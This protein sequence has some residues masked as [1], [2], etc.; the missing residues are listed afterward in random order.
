M[1]KRFKYVIAAIIFT[2]FSQLATSKQQQEVP[3]QALARMQKV[4]QELATPNKNHEFLAQLAGDWTT[5]SKVLG[6]PAE[7]GKAQY[8]M[9]LG[10]RFLHGMRSGSVAGVPFAGL[11]TLGYDNYK[12]KFVASYVDN[13]NT[14]L[15]TAEGLL[16]SSGKILSLWGTMDEW[17]N[18]EHDKLVLYRYI[19]KD[20]R[21]FEFQIHDLAL[22][23]NSLVM[24]VSYVR[25]LTP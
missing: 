14:S 8:S 17:M 4:A 19:Y 21:N 2:T 22:Q 3:G 6:L 25:N 12:H 20:A 15:R 16:D 5:S 18:D 10:N 1:N 23:K 11:L 7:E 24:S 13:L 9:I